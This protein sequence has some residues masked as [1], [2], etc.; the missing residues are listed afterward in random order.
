VA[1]NPDNRI[2]SDDDGMVIVD[3]SEGRHLPDFGFS[4]FDQD[5]CSIRAP[6][7]FSKVISIMNTLFRSISR[8]NYPQEIWVMIVHENLTR[9]SAGQYGLQ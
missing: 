1:A 8:L 5:G 7:S 9:T 6:L 2:R 3:R 4:G